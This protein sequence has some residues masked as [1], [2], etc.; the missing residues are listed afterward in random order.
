MEHYLRIDL[1]AS[2]KV[3]FEN[4]ELTYYLEIFNLLDRQNP[5]CVDELE[6]IREGNTARV[7]IDYSYGFPRL[8]SFGFQYEF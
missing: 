3:M 1:R 2:R 5:C 7:L 8:P 4:S 6:A